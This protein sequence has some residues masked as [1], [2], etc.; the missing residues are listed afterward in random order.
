MIFTEKR[1]KGFGRCL[2]DTQL[3]GE[4]LHYPISEVAPGV[5]SHPQH[6]HGGYEAVHVLEGEAVFE[7]EAERPVLRAGEGVIF[8]PNRLHGLVGGGTGLVRYLVVLSRT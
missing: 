8:D 6:Q 2:V 4:P 1:A 3:K 5:R 7:I